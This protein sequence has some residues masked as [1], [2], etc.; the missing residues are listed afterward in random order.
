MPGA[1]AETV[2]VPAEQPKPLQALGLVE[3][4]LS[5]LNDDG[6]VTASVQ[7]AAGLGAQALSNL[8]SVQA[9][10]VSTGSFTV[11]RRGAGGARYVSV[12]FRIRNAS[13]A[14][15]AS[16]TARQNLTL[17]GAS[18]PNTIGQTPY[19][20]ISRFDGT[21][22]DPSIAPTIVPTPGMAYDRAT[23]TPLPL[24]GAQDLQV[25]TE[26]EVGALGNVTG[27]TRVFPFGF[28]VRN[29]TQTATRTLP[30]NP[31]AGQYD[32]VVTVGLKFPL[33]ADAAADPFAVT[34]MFAVVDDPVTRVTQSTEEQAVA[35]SVQARAAALGAN[36]QI[37]T[38]CGT[39]LAGA[40]TLFV[41]S[42]TTAGNTGRLAGIGGNVALKTP[43]TA[44]SAIGNTTLNVPA[45]QGLASFYS[46]Y[47]SST[48]SFAGTGTA[49]GG[50][51]TVASDGGYSFTSKAGD[52]VSSTAT[53]D[54]LNYAVSDGAGCIS[55]AQTA[56]VNVNQRVWYVNNAANATGDGR[57]TTPFQSLAAAQSVSAAADTI[58]VFRGNG[59]VNGQNAGIVLKDNQVL[60]GEGNELKVGE[61]SVLPAGAAPASIGNAS[62]VGL[63]LASNN[64]V[65]GLN[66]SGTTGGIAGTNFGKLSA[67]LGNVTATALTLASN[68]TVRGL[69]ISGTTGGIAGTNFGKLSATLGNVTATAGPA[70]NLT[71]GTLDAT[72]VRLDA[73]NTAAAGAGV[74]LTGVGG[75]LKVLGAGS[76]GT[77]GTVQA[78]GGVGY[79]IRPGSADLTLGLARVQAQG[80]LNG[81]LFST[82]AADTG[83]VGLTVSDSAFTNNTG[84]AVYLESKGAGANSFLFERNTVSNTSGTSGIVYA[85]ERT[86]TGTN[87]DRGV[88]RNNTIAIG[89]TYAGGG[90]GFSIVANGNSR[91]QFLLENNT[92]SSFNTYG[93]ELRA[94]Q[95]TEASTG[96]AS[97]DLTVRN[98]NISTPNA[99]A[100]ALVCELDGQHGQWAE[101]RHER[102]AELGRGAS[103][104]GDDLHPDGPEWH[105]SN[106]HDEYHRLTK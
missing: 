5:G 51:A 53:A 28:V 92:V 80:S 49:R 82:A 90:S 27:T 13:S 35:G 58:Y 21:P 24:A 85:A 54:S 50:T 29:R 61:V 33:Q 18:T 14:G 40:N 9:D 79:R 30:A 91:G 97:L 88:F 62:G 83:R 36:T 46:V 26:G 52:G 57:Q 93:M 17:L 20:Q 68:N 63:T 98:N 25:F 64:T 55:P 103:A 74:D 41:G 12:T 102:P 44:R 76:A 32:G 105:R 7:P 45:A 73:T 42:A 34:A 39:T 101:R 60:I 100:S 87:V 72:A 19:S 38:L 70:L 75:S 10:V 65:R 16:T 2:P 23:D 99:A 94:G 69:N 4:K 89:N 71:T 11:G 81:L 37:A 47:S 78:T 95:L 6:T 31:A 66:I 86:A 22:A 96:T 106:G 84:R 48:L 8:D 67:T 104:W 77:G 59:T 3:I 43:P 56:P 15:A 1:P